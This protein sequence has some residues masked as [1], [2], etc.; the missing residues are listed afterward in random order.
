MLC[1][2]SILNAHWDACCFKARSRNSPTTVPH[3]DA[4]RARCSRTASTYRTGNLT[5]PTHIFYWKTSV[6]AL[7]DIFDTSHSS[8]VRVERSA[9][10]VSWVCYCFFSK[11]LKAEKLFSLTT[12]AHDKSDQNIYIIFE[13]IEIAI[14][15]MCVSISSNCNQCLFCK[16]SS[17]V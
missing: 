3:S 5:A 9:E 13:N 11:K 1:V 14:V 2:N 12:V 8:V 4:G 15:A 7:L 16:N 10:K 17:A 6:F